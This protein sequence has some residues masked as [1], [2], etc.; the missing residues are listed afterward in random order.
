MSYCSCVLAYSGCAVLCS[1]VVFRKFIYWLCCQCYSSWAYLTEDNPDPEWLEYLNLSHF[2]LGWTADRIPSIEVTLTFEV[3]RP[4]W[5]NA[6]LGKVHFTNKAEG[7]LLDLSSSSWCRM[8]R[9]LEPR[10]NETDVSPVLDFDI[11]TWA[12]EQLR[13]TQRGNHA[14]PHEG[15]LQLLL[16]GG[17]TLADADVPEE[18]FGVN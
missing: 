5:P 7:G 14:H 13:P 16:D 12:P 15:S 6:S 10:Q 9:Y 2:D 4:G 8:C 17:L 1:A 18:Y 3:A 11:I